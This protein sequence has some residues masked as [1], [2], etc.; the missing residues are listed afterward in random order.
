[1]IADSVRGSKVSPADNIARARPLTILRLF[2]SQNSRWRGPQPKPNFSISCHRISPGFALWAMGIA[3]SVMAFA[4][5][6]R[7]RSSKSRGL[8]LSNNW[9]GLTPYASMQWS[10]GW[11]IFGE[12][13][14]A[15]GPF[16]HD[17]KTYQMLVKAFSHQSTYEE[18]G[19]LCLFQIYSFLVWITQVYQEKERR[20]GKLHGPL[21]GRGKPS[22]NHRPTV[23]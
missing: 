20:P 1:M 8:G 7:A 21:A 6:C 4:W 16:K 22:E 17:G 18:W 5:E 2:L 23:K 9:A 10:M 11:L 3:M 15:G 19:I 12:F 13:T 14:W